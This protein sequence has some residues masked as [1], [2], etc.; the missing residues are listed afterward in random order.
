MTAHKTHLG[1]LRLA[2]SPALLALCALPSIAAPQ[3]C[4]D[5][6]PT[7]VS[8]VLLESPIQT[9]FQYSYQALKGMSHRYADYGFAVL[10][11]TTGQVTVKA[12]ANS[13][14]MFLSTPKFH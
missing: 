9:N 3:T 12:K 13:L 7:S 4:E 2:L 14:F 1:V 6:P 5:L 11:L 8:V 10:G